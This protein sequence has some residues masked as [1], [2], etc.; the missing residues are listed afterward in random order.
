MSSKKL[1]TYLTEKSP[2][3]DDVFVQLLS[4]IW[5]FEALHVAVQ[6]PLSMGY[7]RQEYWSGLPFPPLGELTDSRIKSASLASPASAGGFFIPLP[8]G[9]PMQL[10]AKSYWTT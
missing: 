10:I 2:Y 6:A 5:L 3:E 8:P 4:H 1:E 9:I 7:P